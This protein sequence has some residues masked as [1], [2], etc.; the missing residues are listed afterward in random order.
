VL[1]HPMLLLM[2]GGSNRYTVNCEARDDMPFEYTDTL[3]VSPANTMNVEL[4]STA[5]D[6]DFS[7][8][9]FPATC[10]YQ[11]SSDS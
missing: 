7:P 8:H 4:S 10:S 11:H 1:L 2:D 9:S 6:Y 5:E 3:P